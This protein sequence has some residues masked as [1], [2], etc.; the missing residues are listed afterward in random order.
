MEE[1]LIIGQVHLGRILVVTTISEPS[2]Q[3]NTITAVSEDEAASALYLVLHHFTAEHSHEKA[4]ELLPGGTRLC[5]KEPHF[6]QFLEGGAAVCCSQPA[7]IVIQPM[8][9]KLARESKCCSTQGVSAGHGSCWM[10][11][12]DMVAAT[13]LC[14]NLSGRR[15]LQAWAATEKPPSCFSR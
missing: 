2:V 4:A 7:S 1:E 11:V 13:R 9:C 10:K 8:G 15:R 14:F 3:A 6:Q 12:S 5:I